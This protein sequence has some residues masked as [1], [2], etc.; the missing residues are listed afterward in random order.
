MAIAGPA[1]A[2]PA[3]PPASEP[4]RLLLALRRQFPRVRSVEPED[5][6]RSDAGYRSPGFL[7][8]VRGLCIGEG[9]R[10]G[11]IPLVAQ[12]HVHGALDGEIAFGVGQGDAIGEE[13]GAARSV[14]HQQIEGH[15]LAV[16]EGTSLAAAFVFEVD[17]AGGKELHSSHSMLGLGWCE[18]WS[19]RCRRWSEDN[20]DDLR[21][22]VL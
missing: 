13:G 11:R 3:Q 16:L 9:Q 10:V 6:A 22:V 5:C 21:Q 1:V 7:D 15:S 2:L 12:V 14:A 18:G 17:L 20:L 8:G 4:A 19:A